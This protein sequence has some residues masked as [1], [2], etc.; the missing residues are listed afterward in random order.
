[1]SIQVESGPKRFLAA[2]GIRAEVLTHSKSRIHNT[3]T[4]GRACGVSCM[5]EGPPFLNLRTSCWVSCCLHA[6]VRPYYCGSRALVVVRACVSVSS[7]TARALL[8]IKGYISPIYNLLHIVRTKGQ[9][10][11]HQK[12]PARNRICKSSFILTRWCITHWAAWGKKLLS[13]EI[14]IKKTAFN[15]G[16]LIA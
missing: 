11:E 6:C 9:K 16:Q 15:L 4:V 12:G 10:R 14:S 2:C 1:M 5:F 3:L 13:S 7:S 8:G